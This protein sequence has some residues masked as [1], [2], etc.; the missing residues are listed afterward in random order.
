MTITLKASFIT[1]G[2]AY[3]NVKNAILGEVEAAK[4]QITEAIELNKKVDKFF[5]D[6]DEGMRPKI[7]KLKTAKS[8]DR[9]KLFKEIVAVVDN[10]KKEDQRNGSRR[11]DVGGEGRHQ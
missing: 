1:I 11:T 9:P 2:A 6:F 10:Y 4:R 8:T 3:V 7:K 5:D